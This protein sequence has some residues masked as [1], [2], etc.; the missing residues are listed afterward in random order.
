M[1]WA[2]GIDGIILYFGTH[3]LKRITPKDIKRAF[4]KMAKLIHPDKNLDDRAE[5]A[6]IQLERSADILLDEVAR[7]EYDT[8]IVTE[9]R[10][11]RKL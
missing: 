9:I 10:E 5:E 6:F 7:K 3:S 4:Y 8:K 2:Y 1:F 11:R